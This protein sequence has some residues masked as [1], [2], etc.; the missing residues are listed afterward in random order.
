MKFAGKEL[1][2]TFHFMFISKL[3]KTIKTQATEKY[4]N[5]RDLANPMLEL[6]K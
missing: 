4:L 3:Q 6:F 1:C 5:G 2:E